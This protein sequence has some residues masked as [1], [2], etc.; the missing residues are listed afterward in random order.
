[1]WYEWL[2]TVM[3]KRR[4]QHSC[5][6][7]RCCPVMVVTTTPTRDNLGNSSL[8]MVAG[9]LGNLVTRDILEAILMVVGLASS[10]MA[11][12]VVVPEDVVA[13]VGPLQVRSFVTGAGK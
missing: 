5:W 4:S 10:S 13:E 3:L 2:T 11:E 7:N 9:H 1:M 12:V 8:N 6:V